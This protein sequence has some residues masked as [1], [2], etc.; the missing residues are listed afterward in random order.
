VKTLLLILAV[1]SSSCMYAEIKPL[2]RLPGPYKKPPLVDVAERR[3]LYIAGS[4]VIA[5]GI[6][7][8]A[9]AKSRK[10]S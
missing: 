7:G 1:I 10:S 8:L 4:I 5:A 3:T 6:I 2:V 9:I